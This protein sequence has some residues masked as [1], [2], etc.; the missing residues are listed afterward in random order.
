LQAKKSAPFVVGKLRDVP[1][2]ESMASSGKRPNLRPSATFIVVSTLVLT[3]V[4]SQ[5]SSAKGKQQGQT[6]TA[7][8]QDTIVIDHPMDPTDEAILRAELAKMTPNERENF[9]LLIDGERLV[10]NKLSTLSQWEKV[11]EGT[12]GVWRNELGERRPGH[13]DRVEAPLLERFLPKRTAV[14][15]AEG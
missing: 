7:G 9:V 1:Y 14:D 13:L 3:L 15:Q 6:T 12:D 10:S 4:L 11:T 2:T 5:P 8:N